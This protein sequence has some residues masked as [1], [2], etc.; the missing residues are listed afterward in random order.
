MLFMSAVREYNVL[1]HAPHPP[2]FPLFVAAAKLV[3]LLGVSDFHALQI[4]VVLSAVTLFPLTF[5]LARALGFDF[6]TAFGGALVFAFAPNVWFYGGT[7]FSD[8]PALAVL[9]AASVLLLRDRWT[10][11]AVLLGIAVAIRPQAILVGIVP[12]VIAGRRRLAASLAIVILVA[13]VSYLGA[14][15]ASGSVTEFFEVVIEQQEYVTRIDSFQNPV[16]PSLLSLTRTFFKPVR[17]AFVIDKIITVLALIG[18]GIALWRRFRPALVLA[19]MFIPLNVS[20]WLMLDVNASSRYAVSYAPMY[21]ILAVY[22]LPPVRAIRAAVLAVFLVVFV[23]R[24]W[25]VLHEVRTRPSPPVAAM[26]WTLA[27]THPGSSIY[28]VAQ[29][30]PFTRYYLNRYR[31]VIGEDFPASPVSV[32]FSRPPERLLHIAQNRYYKVSVTLNR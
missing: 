8:V 7:A 17:S 24:A 11:G 15:F 13:A 16:R 32:T 23:W 14:G 2:G 22:A 10:A 26:E 18:G 30:Q 6:A 9:L 12:L 3:R 21:A 1:D 20:S 27:R 25:P 31:V 5:L 29:L 28:T 19:L 4:V